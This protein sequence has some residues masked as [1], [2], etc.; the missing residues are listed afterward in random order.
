MD[1]EYAKG[2]KPEEGDVLVGTVTNVDFGWS[3]YRGEYPII[4]VQPEGGGDP[5][6]LHCFHDALFN[7]MSSLRPGIGE[8][9]GVQY[10]G[11]APSKS[12]P[13]NTVARYVV[14]IDGRSTDPWAGRTQPERQ[15]RP[16][17]VPPTG[18]PV[19]AP[20]APADASDFAAPNAAPADDDIPF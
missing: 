16:A 2:W 4:T 1:L 7:R 17:A 11:K 19:D 15:A 13:R 3:E 10:K 18:A 12:N 5:V 14:R 6:A 8:R 20:D 9:I